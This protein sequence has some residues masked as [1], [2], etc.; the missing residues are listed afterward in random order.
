MSKIILVTGTSTGLGISIAVQAAQA[1]NTVY[2]TMRNLDKRGLL[3]KAAEQAGVSLNVLPL[4]VQDAASIDAAVS[5]IIA[6]HGRI[7]VLVNNAGQGFV[8]TVEQAPE[9]DIARV[10]D[11]NYMGVVR[12][13]KAVIPHMRKARAGH[14]VNITSVGGLVGQP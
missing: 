1:G 10:T 11:I 6:V 14:I 2:A 5:Q 7:D 13:I 8:R 3:D 12:T 4:D 9:Q